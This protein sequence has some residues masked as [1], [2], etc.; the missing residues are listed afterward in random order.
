[1]DH[2]PAICCLFSHMTRTYV[3]PLILGASVTGMLSFPLG[4]EAA[5]AICNI[6][7]IFN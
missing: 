6:G 7:S 3:M 2:A 4:S 1:M 5:V